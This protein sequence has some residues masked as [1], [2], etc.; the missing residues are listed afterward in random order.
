VQ[1][2][3]LFGSL[4]VEPDAD[5]ELW[6]NGAFVASPAEGVATNYYAKR[7]LVPFGEFVPFRPLLGWIGKFVPIGGDF[8]PG[9]GS[10]PLVVLLRDQTNIFGP[11][12]CY[13]DVYPRLA[14][15]SVLGGAE[16]LAVLTNNGWFGEGGA[17]FQHAAHS[18]LRAVENRRPVLRVGNSGWSGWID[19]FGVV[20]AVLTDESNRIYFR[21]TE[22]LTISRDARWLERR[23]FYSRH[24]DWFVFCCLLLAGF[25]YAVLR[26]GERRNAVR[27]WS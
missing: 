14:R 20:R 22:T 15:E 18:V 21:G 8:T 13:E 25:G 16:I 26:A 17:A 5:R 1:R 24:G 27:A 19:E 11:L 10:A 9:F 4:A 6:F 3:L 2:P 12:I 7:R 23:T